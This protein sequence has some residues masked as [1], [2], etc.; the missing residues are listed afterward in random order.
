MEKI[1]YYNENMEYMG[2]EN[3]DIVH[4]NGWWHKTVHCWLYDKNGN[5]YFQI[6]RD[7]NKY[8]TTASGH[9]SAGETV[10]EAFG[11]E[12]KEETNLTVDYDKAIKLN[13]TLWSMDSE[14][15]G[16]LIK[17]RAFA[18]VYLLEYNEDASDFTENEE[19]SGLALVNAKD[20]LELFKENK[21][22][23]EATIIKEGKREKK[24]VGIEDFLINKMETGLSKY[25]DILVK[26]I[27]LTKN[28][29]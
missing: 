26:V 20:C 3:R 17:D 6:R 2:T 9:L 13:I 8:Y 21:K 27:N 1:D 5:I 25:G 29:K 24:I 10:K 7:K 15:N 16:V 23:I 28:S 12:T 4:Q 18:N 22:T 14:K 11:R 19:V